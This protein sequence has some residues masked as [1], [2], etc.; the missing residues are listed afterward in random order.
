MTKNTSADS[1]GASSS[2]IGTSPHGLVHPT[3][4]AVAGLIFVALAFLYYET[5]NFDQVSALFS[6]NVPPTM[7]PRVLLVLIGM[8]TLSL[9]F[10]HILL[11][12]KGKNIDKDRTN[13]LPR[14]T[15][16]TMALLV[17]I[18]SLFEFTG[19]IVTMFLVCL[20]MP[21]LWGEKRF[22]VTL[23]FAILFPLAINFVFSGILGVHFESGLF[24]LS[25]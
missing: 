8:L 23:V 2:Q 13:S 15:W 12:K 16:L 19:M 21:R 1:N 17:C 18:L 7:F 10:E 9:P 20:L 6:Q 25:F 14:V 11:A 22:L 24:G 5:T 4:T 3:D